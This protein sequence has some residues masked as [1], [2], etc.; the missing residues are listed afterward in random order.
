MDSETLGFDRVHEE[1]RQRIRRYV[2]R[3]AGEHEAD[4]LTQEVFLKVS[5]ALP[6]FQGKSS[7]STWIYKVATNTVLDRLKSPAHRQAILEAQDIDSEGVAPM[8]DDNPLSV[9]QQLI[10][11]QMSECIREVVA[12]LP[13]DYRAVIA[14]SEMEDLKNSEIADVL[15]ISL[16]AAKIRLHRARTVLKKELEGKCDFYRDGRNEFACEPKS[17]PIKFKK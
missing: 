2:A 13:P 10:R 8:P 4:D 7:L 11:E 15:G 1:Y 17:S 9:D 5:R 14:L 12:K 6:D 3:L 16:D